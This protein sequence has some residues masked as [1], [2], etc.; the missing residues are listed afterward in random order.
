[1]PKVGLLIFFQFG[2]HIL[3]F[4]TLKLYWHVLLHSLAINGPAVFSLATSAAACPLCPTVI[5]WQAIGRSQWSVTPAG[6][7]A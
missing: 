3:W 6:V 5:G 4:S 7:W 1:M 2:L